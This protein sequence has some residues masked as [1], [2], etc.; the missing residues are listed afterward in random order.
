MTPNDPKKW[1]P[2]YRRWLSM[3]TRC[4]NPRAPKY[5]DYGARGIRVCKRWQNDFAAFL[6]DVG[7][8]PS[9]K[10]TLE[11][12]NNDGHYEPRNVRWATPSEQ[13]R[14]KR[15]N[16]V[17]TF[18]GESLCLV[19]WAERVGIGYSTLSYRIRRGWPAEK[20]LTTPARY[21]NR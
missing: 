1:H 13:G 21:G 5:R 14:N 9:P 19:E 20:A 11:R 8:A 7:E 10:H 4:Y 12:V 16:V 6:A 18:C 17:V 3:K 2:L 15:G